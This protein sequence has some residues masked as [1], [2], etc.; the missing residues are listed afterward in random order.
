M[1]H[2]RRSLR[3]ISPLY[4]AAIISVV[5]SFYIGGN[6][7]FY[8]NDGNSNDDYDDDKNQNTNWKIL[9][10][11]TTVS[12]CQ[13]AVEQ[14]NATNMPQHKNNDEDRPRL[15]FL[16]TGS[17]TGCPKPICA[18]KF[19]KRNDDVSIA[20]DNSK[21]TQPPPLGVRVKPN[22]TSCLVSHLAIDGGDPK[23][24]RNYRN[25]PSLL[26]HHYDQHT[27][28]YKNIVIDVGK[29]FRE[30]ALRWFPIIE[31]IHSLDAIV[32][33]HHHMDAA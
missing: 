13:S 18:M 5:A 27:K 6:N 16:G 4:P 9:P 32:L 23:S 19:Q 29:T 8:D 15:V 33:T 12:Y 26:V 3:H 10:P 31:G 7:G 1:N 30:T 11:P 14:R 20:E 25:N 22:S 2:F 17:S 21:T 28:T 24:N